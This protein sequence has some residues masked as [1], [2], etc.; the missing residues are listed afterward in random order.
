MKLIDMVLW[1]N[2]SFCDGMVKTSQCERDSK[3]SWAC[4]LLQAVDEEFLNLVKTYDLA[5]KG[6]H[7][8]IECGEI[9]C[10]FGKVN[11]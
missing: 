6:P 3:L 10:R 1:W 8:W 11:W 2:I 5:D 9:F 4:G 7:L